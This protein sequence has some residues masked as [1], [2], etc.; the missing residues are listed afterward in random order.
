MVRLFVRHSVSNYDNWRKIFDE[1][2]PTARTMGVMEPSVL[3]SVDDP[4]DV[5]VTHDFESVEKAR[6]FVGSDD[7]RQAMA[8]AGVAGEPQIWIATGV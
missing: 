3:R 2:A 5:T 1:F 8:K 6:A 4:S 7:L